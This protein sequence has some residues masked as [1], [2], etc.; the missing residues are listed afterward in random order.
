MPS[1]QYSP[2]FLRHHKFL[3]MLPIIILPFLI[4]LF[5]ILG[6]G[7]ASSENLTAHPATGLNT[8]L[9]DAHIKKGNEK[10]KL[11]LYE[12]ASKDSAILR[13][14]I[15]NDPY[16][17]LEPHDSSGVNASSSKSVDQHASRIMSQLAVL[18]SVLQHQ[19][20]STPLDIPAP[21]TG[22]RSSLYPPAQNDPSKMG[23]LKTH[24]P[25]IDQLNTLLD[26]V[27]VI[28][29]PEMVRDSLA[30]MDKSRM[31]AAFHV[32]VSP[33]GSDIRNFWIGERKLGMKESRNPIPFLR[34]G[35]GPVPSSSVAHWPGSRPS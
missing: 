2:R 28:Q 22:T 12:E 26:K 14:K 20:E 18:K 25:D 10:S 30:V 31:E 35:K 3:L 17:S 33:V 7:K 6:G 4:L 34:S 24:N 29:H 23:N 16:Y 27:M 1:I 15:K 9:P 8:K 21:H 32:V 13:E 11:S 19:K 5:I